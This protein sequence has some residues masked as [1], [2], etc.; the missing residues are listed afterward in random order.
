MSSIIVAMPRIEDAK[1]INEM[2]KRRG[3]EAALCT[4]GSHVLSKV[5]QLD[6]GVVIC[7][8]RLSDMYYVQ[9]AEYL[10]DSFELLL[11]ASPAVVENSPPG[12]MTLT[13]PV[14]AGDLN[15]TVELMLAQQTRRFKRKGPVKRTWQEQNYIDNAKRVL[16]ERNHMSEQEAF[17]YIQKNS[18]DSGTN[19][20][21]TAQ[22]ILLM[23][24]DN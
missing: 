24:L 15:G 13:M 1:H 20:A 9:L 3:L 16:M 11:I 10:P 6:Y 23:N 2:L 8:S 17:R 22:M 19:M 21:E 12:M 7:A 4:T 18:M 14:R 5:H